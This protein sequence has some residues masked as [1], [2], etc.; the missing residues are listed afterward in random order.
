MKGYSGVIVD[1][2]MVVTERMSLLE[3]SEQF[4]SAKISLLT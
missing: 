2:A 3:S 4:P 1:E